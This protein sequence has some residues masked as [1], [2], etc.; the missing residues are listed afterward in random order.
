MKTLK[1]VLK[2][3]KGKVPEKHYVYEVAVPSGECGDDDD[4][5]VEFIVA[6]TPAQASQAV[7][8][9]RRVPDKELMQAAVEALG[10][11]AKEKA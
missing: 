2:S 9:V 4:V 3:L 6:K 1:E 10:E 8:E 7:T 11:L 5:F